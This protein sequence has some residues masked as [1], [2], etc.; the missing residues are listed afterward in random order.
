MPTKQFIFFSH[1][2][3]K[4]DREEICFQIELKVTTHLSPLKQ[5]INYINS[6]VIFADNEERYQFGKNMP[7]LSIGNHG[8]NR[9]HC[10]PIST[11]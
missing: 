4:N 11:E 10:L 7:N 1:I 8:F 9:W 2:G 5:L 3:N 6:Y